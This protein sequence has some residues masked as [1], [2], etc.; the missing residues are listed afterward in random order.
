MSSSVHVVAHWRDACQEM[1]ADGIVLGEDACELLRRQTGSVLAGAIRSVG[2]EAI[3]NRVQAWPLVAEL[4]RVAEMASSLETHDN[5]V[6]VGNFIQS[7]LPPM[8]SLQDV[9]VLFFSD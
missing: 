3:F 1:P 7:R 9:Y 5:L 4:V 6:A 8:G 2:T